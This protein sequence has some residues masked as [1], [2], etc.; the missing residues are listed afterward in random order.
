MSGK[1]RVLNTAQGVSFT[2]PK[3]PRF[4]SDLLHEYTE[5]ELMPTIKELPDDPDKI[6][7]HVRKLGGHGEVGWVHPGC[8]GTRKMV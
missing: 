2:P 4:W 7:E 1:E 6:L 3:T 5:L 8:C